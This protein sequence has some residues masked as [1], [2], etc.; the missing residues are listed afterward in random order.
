MIPLSPA[1]HTS[2]PDIVQ[3]PYTPM[4]LIEYWLNVGCM[5]D[6]VLPSQCNIPDVII[7]GAVA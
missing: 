4:G 7:P 6:H 5:T 1:T 3:M 2:V